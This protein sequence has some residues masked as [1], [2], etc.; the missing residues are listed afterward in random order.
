MVAEGNGKHIAGFY[1]M[2]KKFWYMLRNCDTGM[3]INEIEQYQLRAIEKAGPYSD[4]MVSPHNDDAP[5]FSDNKGHIW[6]D[7]SL[8]GWTGYSYRREHTSVTQN[9]AGWSVYPIRF[10]ELCTETEG[11][12]WL[13]SRQQ[14]SE[15][16]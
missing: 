2:I 9:I 11:H 15:L 4:M 14:L 1:S 6:E 12:M 7:W 10:H 8:K 16:K 3:Y 5:S 13:P